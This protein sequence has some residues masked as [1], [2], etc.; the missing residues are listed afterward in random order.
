MSTI[1]YLFYFIPLHDN[2][3]VGMRSTYHGLLDQLAAFLLSSQNVEKSAAEWGTCCVDQQK[4]TSPLLASFHEQIHSFLQDA[5]T[6]LIRDTPN[7]F[8]GLIVDMCSFF[9]RIVESLK[10]KVEGEVDLWPPNSSALFPGGAKNAVLSLLQWFRRTNDVAPLRLLVTLL[11]HLPTDHALLSTLVDTPAFI[12]AIAADFKKTMEKIRALHRAQRSSPGEKVEKKVIQYGLFWRYLIMAVGYTNYDMLREYMRPDG[13]VIYDSMLIV[14]KVYRPQIQADGGIRAVTVLYTN[15][16]IFT[17]SLLPSDYT[18]DDDPN[19][20]LNP[21]LILRGSLSFMLDPDHHPCASDTCPNPNTKTTSLCSGCRFM[22]YCSESCQREA[23]SWRA[24][25]HKAV[26]KDLAKLLMVRA[27]AANDAEFKGRL[28]A[29][30][31]GND[32]MRDIILA[33]GMPGQSRCLSG[34][35]RRGKK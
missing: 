10:V 2:W 32:K 34:V 35:A 20:F 26:C 24:A 1:K 3:E 18:N 23:W 29:G 31:F 5:S 7:T 11:Q 25:P 22:R 6:S 33:L 13:Q 12:S 14:L 21:S 17:T 8:N 16:L 30:G 15:P 4:T 9:A 28:E 27:E 19:N